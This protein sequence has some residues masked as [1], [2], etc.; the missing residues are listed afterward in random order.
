MDSTTPTIDSRYIASDGA[1]TYS[2]GNSTGCTVDSTTG[3]VSTAF[4]G[5]SCLITG[6]VSQGSFYKSAFATITFTIDSSTI[7]HE[8]FS[9]NDGS[10][11][12]NV[13]SGR[14]GDTINAPSAPP[15]D[16]YVFEGWSLSTTGDSLIS[17]GTQISIIAE[18]TY[19]A[20]WRDTSTVSA[21]QIT[22][23]VVQRNANDAVPTVTATFY[24]GTSSTPVV[25][26][27][28]TD[29]IAQAPTVTSSGQTFVG[30]SLDGST[31]IFSDI[32][33]TDASYYAVWAAIPTTISSSVGP[34]GSVSA[35]P[36]TPVPYGQD[37]T[38]TFTPDAGYFVQKLTVD[39]V[40]V[41]VVTSNPSSGAVTYTFTAVT[42]THVISGAFAQI[43]P[44]IVI[45]KDANVSA[46][47]ISGDPTFGGNET[48]TIS[49][50]TNYYI[51]TVT[52]D[53]VISTYTRDYGSVLV[54]FSNVTDTHSIVVQSA[55]KTH[56]ITLS[57]TP[58]VNVFYQ[59]SAATSSSFGASWTAVP[60]DHVIRIPDGSQSSQFGLKF[61]AT[62]GYTIDFS[63]DSLGNQFEIDGT[64]GDSFATYFYRNNNQGPSSTPLVAYFQSGYLVG[65]DHT[66]TFNSIL[67]TSTVSA[68]AVGH[69][70]IQRSRNHSSK[71]G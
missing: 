28:G 4:S 35:N 41:N 20:I 14:I 6:T 29:A 2:A 5:G 37:Q 9:K 40:D 55:Q 21:G 15:R 1:V 19:Y 30:W 8:Y 12:F 62:T 71:Q 25:I 34:H 10:G 36:L 46:P 57:A 52:V 59:L 58:G 39:G 48:Y 50:A 64:N 54:A 42:T 26:N 32:I 24:N 67:D 47:T 27:S 45:T 53:G 69:G 23:P 11:I 65:L 33:T 7:N 18:K 44:T 68:S 66:F 31:V 16:G 38:F 56:N 13:L 49:A 22:A 63:F 17:P 3:V 60:S 70:T 43:T 61:V 51:E